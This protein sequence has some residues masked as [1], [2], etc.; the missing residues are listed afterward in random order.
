[1]ASALPEPSDNNTG[2]DSLMS[3]QSP[4]SS[5]IAAGRPFGGGGHVTS[6]HALTVSTLDTRL[7]KA[8]VHP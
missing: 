3:G 2:F 5:R 8:R 7:T 1:M 6:S 4:S